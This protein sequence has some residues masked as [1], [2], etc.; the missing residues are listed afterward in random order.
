MDIAAKAVT[1]D[2]IPLALRNRPTI[3]SYQEAYLK[4]FEELSS[5]RQFTQ[6]GV[7]D[8]PYFV[9]IMWLDENGIF[10]QDE[11][12]DYLQVLSSLDTVYISHYYEKNKVK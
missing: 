7:A 1:E 3:N 5:S 2:E 11:R 9:K 6:G 10:D 8:I 12:N 4:M